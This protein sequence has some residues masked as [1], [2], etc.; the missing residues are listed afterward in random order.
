LA[1]WEG[2]NGYAVLPAVVSVVRFLDAGTDEVPE[3]PTGRRVCTLAHL[4]ELFE[5]VSPDTKVK[6]S[7]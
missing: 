7:A 3:N 1:G 5:E 2:G 6:G 4:G